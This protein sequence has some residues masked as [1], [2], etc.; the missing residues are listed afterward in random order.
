MEVLAEAWEF[1]R[2]YGSIERPAASA[3]DADRPPP[4]RHYVPG[5]SHRQPRQQPAGQM[6][7]TLLITTADMEVFGICPIRSQAFAHVPC[8]SAVRN[9]AG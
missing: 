9:S 1:Q 5:R 2:K 7:G 6:T 3:E 8:A 4:F